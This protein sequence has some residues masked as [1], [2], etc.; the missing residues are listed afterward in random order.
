MLG[1]HRWGI[2]SICMCVVVH[3]AAPPQKASLSLPPHSYRPVNARGWKRL[4]PDLFVQRVCVTHTCLTLPR[5][6][7]L[8]WPVGT[9]TCKYMNAHG[10]VSQDLLPKIRLLLESTSGTSSTALK[11]IRLFA[12]I[13]RHHTLQTGTT[14]INGR[15]S[16][17]KNTAVETQH[18]L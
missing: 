11:R 5:H 14:L 9:H 15:N 1:Q 10:H 8:S 16:A 3:V 4:K 12:P 18:K 6:T 7:H 17:K 2:Y 13:I